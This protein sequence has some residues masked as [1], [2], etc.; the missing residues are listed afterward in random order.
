MTEKTTPDNV[1]IKGD[2]IAGEAPLEALDV[3]GVGAITPGMLLERTATGTVQPHSGAAG[4]VAP[5]MWAVEAA[6]FEGGDI[7]TD[8][9]T[10][11]ETVLYKICYP[12]AHV[13]AFLAAGN[14]TVSANVLLA[15]NGDGTLRVSNTNPVARALEDVDNDPGTGGAAVRIKAEVL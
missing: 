12:G 8:Y 10:D 2:W 6:L 11:G 1:V 3:Y 13:Y 14:D 7:D 5:K 15:S 4:L 9:D